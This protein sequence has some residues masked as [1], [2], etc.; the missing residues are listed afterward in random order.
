MQ[1]A[2][3]AARRA[4]HQRLEPPARMRGECTEGLPG[5]GAPEQHGPGAEVEQ[6]AALGGGHGGQ[7]SHVEEQQGQEGKGGARKEACRHEWGIKWV[8]E[9]GH[10]WDLKRSLRN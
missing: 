4:R 10:Q 5:P 3:G 6:A 2:T 9:W 1:G 8:S 7:G